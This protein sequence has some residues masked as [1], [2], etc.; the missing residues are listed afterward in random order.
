MVGRTIRQITILR[1]K[2]CRPDTPA[3][4]Q[5]T[6]VGRRIERLDRRAKYLVFNLNPRPS[7]TA[8]PRLLAHL[9]MTGRLFVQPTDVPLPGH[10]AAVLRLDRGQLVFQDTRYF[11]RLTLD[12]T[13]LDRLGPEP[14]GIHFTPAALA[15]ALGSSR[16]AVKVRLLDQRA[17]AGLGNIYAS[18]ALFLARIHPERPAGQLHPKE[19]AALHRSIQTVLSQA[20]TVGSTVPLNWSGSTKTDRLFY[21]GR[22]PDAP[23]SYEERL[24]VYDRAGAP[25]S[26]RRCP[27]TIRRIL[28]A[29]RSTFLCPQCQSTWG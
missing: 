26:R 5:K 27:G 15:T 3:C 17:I 22:H 7:E 21:Y 28:Q 16:Q 13:P 2:T 6:L 14:L 20:I 4:L 29:G 24:R 19:I 18:E 8:P 12:T 9:G 11:G 1:A 25:C 23:G 10:T